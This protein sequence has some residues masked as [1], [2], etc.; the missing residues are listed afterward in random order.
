MR[1]PWPL[2]T[3]AFA[4]LLVTTALQSGCGPAGNEPLRTAPGTDT[5]SPQEKETDA[6]LQKSHTE[7]NKR[8]K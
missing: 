4:F 2:R 7:Y 8:F 6:L 3:L 5:R 1:Y